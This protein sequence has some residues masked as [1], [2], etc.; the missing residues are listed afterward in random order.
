MHFWQSGW[1]WQNV[2]ANQTAEAVSV[3]VY[4]IG[5]DPVSNM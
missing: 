2:K 5:V 1:E 3:G 4:P